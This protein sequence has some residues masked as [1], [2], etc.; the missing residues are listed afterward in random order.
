VPTAFRRRTG[1]GRTRLERLPAVPAKLGC[2][3]RAPEARLISATFA[4]GCAATAAG[5][6]ETVVPVNRSFRRSE[7]RW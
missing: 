4:S 3:F 7:A 6:R 1:S 5:R 2:G